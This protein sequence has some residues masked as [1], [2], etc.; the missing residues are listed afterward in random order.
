MRRLSWWLVDGT[1]SAAF[2]S[3]A[4][5]ARVQFLLQ[6]TSS[7]RRC[8]S[9]VGQH[10]YCWCI[11]YVP[12]KH[13]VCECILAFVVCLALRKCR[14]LPVGKSAFATVVYLLGQSTPTARCEEETLQ[15]WVGPTR[16]NSV[17]NTFHPPF[18]EIGSASLLLLRVLDIILSFKHSGPH[19]SLSASSSVF[20]HAS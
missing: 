15:Q 20:C 16:A 19:F 8:L 14:I 9:V 5:V 6:H 1:K 11:W 13:H 7:V 2:F 12:D 18:H 17:S 4:G 10:Y 3:T